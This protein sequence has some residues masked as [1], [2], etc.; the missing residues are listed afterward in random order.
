MRVW[1]QSARTV[2]EKVDKGSVPQE[3]VGGQGLEPRQ[4]FWIPARPR[5]E[6]EDE[7]EREEERRVEEEGHKVPRVWLP[8]R[9]TLRW[10]VD[11]DEEDRSERGKYK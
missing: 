4:P 2:D 6:D 11:F 10:H 8:H 1:A 5:D 7:S 3:P 9:H